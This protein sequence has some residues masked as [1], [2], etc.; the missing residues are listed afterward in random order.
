[1]STL[2][3]NK[4]NILFIGGFNTYI[5]DI[6][7]PI[8]S[9]IESKYFVDNIK[10]QTNTN[11]KTICNN[12]IDAI[13]KNESTYNYIIVHSMGGFLI[14]KVLHDINKME[15]NIKTNIF[16]K[17]SDTKFILLNPMI[18]QLAYIKLL[19]NI[20][21]KSLYDYLYFPRILATPFFKLDNQSTF[22]SDIYKS[23]SYSIILCKQIM[24]AYNCPEFINFDTFIDIYKDSNLKL[25]IIYSTYDELATIKTENLNKLQL[26]YNLYSVFGKHEPF[27][28]NNTKDL[29]NNFFKILNKLLE[30]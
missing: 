3:K 18:E 20:I 15:H 30:E 4:S 14:T 10:Y 27:N 9:E 8:L 24:E 16:N 25:S 7:D 2:S 21:P 23:E 6:Y 12:I 28:N 5:S 13:R 17:L 22:F 19:N 11:I 29:Q 1:M 26:K